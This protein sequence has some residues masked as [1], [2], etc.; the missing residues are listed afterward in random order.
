MYANESL[1]AAVK[2]RGI[3]VSA[4]STVRFFDMLEQIADLFDAIYAAFG[5]LLAYQ[6][7]ILTVPI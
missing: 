2:I 5:Y 3:R 1:R 6:L 7:V 4:C